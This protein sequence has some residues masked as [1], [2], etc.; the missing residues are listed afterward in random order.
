MIGLAAGLVCYF[1]VNLKDVLHFDDSLDVVGVHMVGGMLGV[2]LTGVFASLA[3]NAAGEAG[4]LVQLGRQ[5]V[6]AAVGIAFPFVMTWIILWV[7]DHTV[8]LRVTAEDELAGLDAQRARRDRLPARRR[9]PRPGPLT[10]GREPRRA[11]APCRARRQA[12]S[13]SPE[14]GITP[15]ARRTYPGTKRCR[16]GRRACPGRLSSRWWCSSARSGPGS[17]ARWPGWAT[18]PGCCA[19]PRA[20]TPG[21]GPLT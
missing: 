19:T 2:I 14:S 1:A 13:A 4:G 16:G 8:G 7:T 10:S 17:T 21:T 6:L 12:R 15:A 5:L 11:G 20:I 18:G 3:V 9:I